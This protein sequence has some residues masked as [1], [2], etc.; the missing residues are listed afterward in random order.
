MI[1]YVE[2][3][4]LF[5]PTGVVSSPRIAIEN[6]RFTR[7][8][9]RNDFEFPAAA[10]VEHFKGKILA[11]GYID[12]HIHGNAGHDV[13]EATPDA[14]RAVELSLAKRGVTA[15]L[16]T[17]VTAPVDRTLDALKKL[18][19]WISKHP[20]GSGATPLGLHLEGPFI[21]HAKRGVHPPAHIQPPSVELFDRFY[22]AAAGRVRLMTVAPEGTGA[23]EMI[24]HAT[25]KH[26][27]ISVGHSDATFTQARAAIEAGAK[28]ATHTFN[29]MRPLDHRE[30]GILGAV[31]AD[32]SLFAEIIADGIHV[33]PAIVKTFVRAKGFDRSILVTDAISATGM[34]DG[35]Y[36]LGDF[37]VTV[38]GDRAE[39]EGRLAGSVLTL[40]R[41]V[42]NVS[43]FASIALSNSAQMATWN[44][45]QLLGLTDRGAIRDNFVADFNVL[46]EN[47]TIYKTVLAGSAR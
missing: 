43:D 28:H 31:L 41:A 44:P 32:R 23:A 16:P 25:S 30:P 46:N 19:D 42:R 35:T 6:G 2:A 3:D 17:T 27:T 14:L 45:A 4:Q 47:G 9:T 24:G 39:F 11:P 10:S 36:Q 13:M 38:R 7:V 34:G 12:I 29:A 40:D 26:V 37:S 22:E 33:H 5:T 18:G 1:K 21:S 20:S 15:Y 8:G